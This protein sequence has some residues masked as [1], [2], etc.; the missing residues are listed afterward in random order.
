MKQSIETALRQRGQEIISQSGDMHILLPYLE[1]ESTDT[2]KAILYKLLN[3]ESFRREFRQW[4]YS[5]EPVK[6]KSFLSYLNICCLFQKDFDKQFQNQEKRIQKYAH[7]FEWFI[8]QMLI[9]KFGAKATGF[10]IRLKDAS[11]DDEFDCIGLIDDGLTFVECKTGNK[12]IL[13]EIEKFSRRDAELCAD[14]SFFIL[15]ISLI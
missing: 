11:P 12:D 15:D 6:N 7:T 3:F 1:A 8:S 9:K 10:G 4:A 14:Y 5:K 13:S 2:L